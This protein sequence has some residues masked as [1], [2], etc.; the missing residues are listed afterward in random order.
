MG[1]AS[2]PEASYRVHGSRAR[3]TSFG[4]N[5]Q[6]AITSSGFVRETQAYTGASPDQAGVAELIEQQQE[7]Q[8]YYPK[9]LIYDQAAGTGK[10]RAEVRAISAGQTQLVAKLPP[11]EK[12]T[13]RFGPYDFSL[14]EDGK[15]LTCPG[16]KSTSIGCPAHNRDGREFRFHAYQCWSCEPP[17]HMN[18]ADLTHRCPLWEKCRG[19]KQGPGARR[20]VFISDYRDEVIAAQVYNQSEEFEADLR[21]RPQIERV[22]FELT[23]YNGAR[24]CR[25]RG[26]INADWQAKMCA[27][28]YNLK[29]WMR[30]LAV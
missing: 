28:A 25:K 20:R 21:Q 12:R 3:Q 22:V 24:H 9:K 16:G 7:H 4:Y 11:Y 10:A 15:V 26:L 19:V 23:H 6:F 14:S 1:S 5:I 17:A 13:E 29:C 2:D 30:R 18:E 27:V 8:G